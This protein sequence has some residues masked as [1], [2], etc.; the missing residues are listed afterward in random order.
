MNGSYGKAAKNIEDFVNKLGALISKPIKL[1]DE[2]LST[3]GA[4]RMLIEAGI[5]RKKRNKVDDAVAACIILENYVDS[6]NIGG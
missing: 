5:K 3:A 4:N 6:C 1:Q 2:R